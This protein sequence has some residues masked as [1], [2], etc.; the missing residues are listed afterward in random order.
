[1]GEMIPKEPIHINPCLDYD[2]GSNVL[3][4]GLDRPVG[5]VKSG[6][7]KQSVRYGSI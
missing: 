7:D 6:T 5:P 1:M 2:N 4:S 3:K